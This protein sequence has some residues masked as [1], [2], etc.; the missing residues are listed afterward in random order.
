MIPEPRLLTEKDLGAFSRI[1]SAMFEES[2]HAFASSPYERMSSHPSAVAIWLPEREHEVMVI[3]HPT[4]KGQLATIV[5]LRRET[6][7]HLRHKAH[8]WGVYTVRELRGQGFGYRAMSAAI[9]LV[10]TWGGVDVLHVRVSGD[11]PEA[12]E[13][14]ETLGFR[15]WAH[16]EDCVRIDGV[17]YPER[18]LVLEL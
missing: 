13:L 12:L 7:R 10:R 16:E 4:E 18:R 8:A 9:G 6:R 5:G 1:R 2:P 15:V 11:V 3:D 17:S 14:Y